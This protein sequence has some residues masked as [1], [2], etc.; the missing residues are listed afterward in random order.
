MSEIKACILIVEKAPEMRR[1]LRRLMIDEGFNVIDAADMASARTLVC[2]RD[3]CAL[4]L[5]PDLP[6]GDGIDLIVDIR[7]RSD[8]PI[9]VLTERNHEEGRLEAFEVGADDYVAKPFSSRELLARLKA[10]LRRQTACVISS[11]YLLTFDDIEI[12]LSKRIVCKQKQA[13][14]LTPIEYRLL[15]QLAR[16]PQRVF[17]YQELLNLVWG[18]VHDQD[19]HYLRVHMRNLRKKIEV[20]PS[21][22]RHLLTEAHMGYRFVP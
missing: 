19:T 11:H 15:V 20:D 5:D 3:P 2:R 13:I 1:L 22:P 8:L 18:G 10:L 16:Y 14:H 6:D 4:V 12:D 7:S 9:L 17:L 21:C